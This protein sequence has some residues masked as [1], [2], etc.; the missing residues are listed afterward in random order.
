MRGN[1]QQFDDSLD[2]TVKVKKGGG[3]RDVSTTPSSSSLT[4][5]T[6]TSS[7]PAF[8]SPS[9]IPTEQTIDPSPSSTLPL[10]STDNNN[11][12]SQSIVYVLVPIFSIVAFASLLICLLLYR[13]KKPRRNSQ[14]YFIRS[15]RNKNDSDDNSIGSSNETTVVS[16]DY[17][18]SGGENLSIISLPKRPPSALL[19]QHASTVLQFEA[20][21]PHVVVVDME[22]SAPHRGS[23]IIGTEG[24]DGGCRMIKLLQLDERKLE[25][26]NYGK[27][28]FKFR[29]K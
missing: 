12:R 13:R 11:N 5:T 7:S 4:S 9:F 17:Q 23:I 22:D 6:S 1:Y 15:I 29:K 16:M 24:R 10:S 14:H 20:M 21:H 28:F 27:G 26:N 18:K 25:N 3:Y 2:Y 8:S 19:G